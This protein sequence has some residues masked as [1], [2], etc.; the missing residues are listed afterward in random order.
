MNNSEIICVRNLQNKINAFETRVLGSAGGVVERKV[1][2]HKDMVGLEDATILFTPNG[3]RVS[4]LQNVIPNTATGD[5]TFSRASGALRINSSGVEEIVGNNV[6]RIDYRTGRNA[7][8]NENQSTNLFLNSAVGV[9]QNIATVNNPQLRPYWLHF[10]GTGSIVVS[11]SMTGTV[12]GTGVN[13]R[14]FLEMPPATGTATL[15]VTG[16]V[17][18]VQFE[19]WFEPTSYIATTGSIMTRVAENARVENVSSI[20]NGNDGSF[21]IDFNFSRLITNFNHTK[22]LCSI[23]FEFSSFF[24]ISI[25]TSGITDTTNVIVISRRISNEAVTRINTS[26]APAVSLG[27]NRLI[28]TYQG[29]KTGSGVSYKIFLN[30]SLVQTGFSAG[31]IITESLNTYR[32]GGESNFF[33]GVNDHIISSAYYNY[34]IS[35]NKALRN[36][37]L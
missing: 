31:T 1:Q 17:T 21:F 28:V 18:K 12:N 15:T 24:V 7:H 3:Y 32:I 5:F 23:L 19:S 11:G 16:T 8:L 10:N 37:I 30:G 20:V 34:A 6:P 35:D 22:S 9:T 29:L 14:V 2:M 4:R 13:D 26:G 33:Q 27:R 36:T 25:G